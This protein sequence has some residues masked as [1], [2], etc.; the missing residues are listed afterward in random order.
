MI[1]PL[2]VVVLVVLG[3]LAVFGVGSTIAKRP[4]GRAMRLAVAGSVALLVVQ[5]VIAAA[6]VLTGTALPETS[7][8][9]IYLVVSVVVLPVALQF[10][11]ATDQ[12]TGEGPTRWGGTVVA[13]AAVAVA[14]AVVRLVFLWNAGH[15]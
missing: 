7:T 4:P 15:A 1:G 13:V 3:A 8:F 12:D 9:L 5:A 6:R 10:A 2:V 11:T 14:V